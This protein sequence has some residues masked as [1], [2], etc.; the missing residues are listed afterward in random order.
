MI[1]NQLFRLLE[2]YGTISEK[3]S[4]KIE[5]YFKPLEV[6]TKQILIE[7]FEPANKL[8]FVNKG[9][10]RAYYINENGKEITRMIAWENRFLTNLASFRGAFENNEIIESI[11]NSEILYINR[12]DFEIL[13]KSSYNLKCIYTD[14]MEEYHALHVKRFEILNAFDLQKK[15]QHL[16]LDFPH[17]IK[18]LNDNLLA[19]FLGISRI[20]YVNNKHLMY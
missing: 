11:K 10:L 18:E 9:F 3:E 19:S 8:F 20:H 15:F 16:K 12:K 4:I 17:L 2:K 14:I 6:K 7:K 5:K 13:I 1:H